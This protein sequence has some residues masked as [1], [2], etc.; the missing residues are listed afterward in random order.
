M[1][2][3]PTPEEDARTLNDYCLDSGLISDRCGISSFLDQI[4]A[5]F[6]AILQEDGYT[7]TQ[8]KAKLNE[9]FADA[10]SFD[11]RSQEELEARI[12][13]NIDYTPGLMSPSDVFRL[14]PGF[15]G[16]SKF[17]FDVKKWVLAG[18]NPDGDWERTKPAMRYLQLWNDEVTKDER[19]HIIRRLMETDKSIA[20]HPLALYSQGILKRISDD[21]SLISEIFGFI[22]GTK[23]VLPVLSAVP[24]SAIPERFRDYAEKFTT[25]D[26]SALKSDNVVPVRHVNNYAGTCAWMGGAHHET[27]IEE[28]HADSETHGN[29]TLLYVDG[30]LI[31]SMKM[32]RDRSI[33]GLR[34]VQDS[35]GRHPVVIDGVYVTTKEITEQAE[36]VHKE[37][38]KWAKLHLSKLPL[39]PMEFAWIYEGYSPLSSQGNEGGFEGVEEYANVLEGIREKLENECCSPKYIFE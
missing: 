2:V 36:E 39:F 14:L 6:L 33:M 34:T 10:S 9:I 37:Q 11:S 32:Y 18:L 21:P 22:E 27:L 17:D 13:F 25:L 28:Y 30:K 29:V 5:P 20:G 12:K 19:R 23:D 24:L 16:L 4:Q 15:I 7:S 26:K 31:G 3:E 8:A 1:R 38:G 35:E